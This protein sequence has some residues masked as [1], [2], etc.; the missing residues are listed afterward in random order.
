MSAKDKPLFF[1]FAAF[2]DA[3]KD[4]VMHA[5]FGRRGGV[6]KGRYEGLN[7]GPGSGDDPEFVAA[8]RAKVAESMGVTPEKL[9][10]MYQVHGADCLGVAGPW[11][12]D[13]PNADA[14]VTD[15][16]GIALTVL[17]ADCAPVLLLGWAGDKP[18]IGAAHAGWR[19]AL[20]GVLEAAVEKMRGEY[21][22]ETDTLRAAIGPCIQKKSYEVSAEFQNSFI[23]RSHDYERFFQEARKPGHFM[24]DLPGFCAFRLYESGVRQVFINESDT[25]SQENDFFSFRRATH[26]SQRDEAAGLLGKKDYG[27]QIAGIAIR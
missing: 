1:Q 22:V 14:M 24:F 8:N 17:T 12:D 9:L 10:S 21:G 7:C 6:S 4:G 19:G 3:A 2:A 25:Y 26:Q 13:R 18:V 5:F 15:V 11:V 20:G 16:P 23:D 27:R